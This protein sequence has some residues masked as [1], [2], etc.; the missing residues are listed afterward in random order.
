MTLVDEWVEKAEVDYQAAAAL[1]RRRKTPLPD[2]VCY[3]CQQ[4]AEKYLKAY[5]IAQ[6]II[7]SRTHDLEQLLKTC[8]P[9]DATLATQLPLVRALN[10]YGVQIRYPGTSATVAEAKNA[11]KTMRRLRTVLRRKLGL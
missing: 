10:P 5:L 3:H 8:A 11:V 1:N 6:G 7:P 2:A 4:C 9:H